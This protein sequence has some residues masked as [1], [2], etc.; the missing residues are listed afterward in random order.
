MR[1]NLEYQSYGHSLSEFYY[2]SFVEGTVI[3]V[4]KSYQG[5]FY[6][7]ERLQEIFHI[8]KLLKRRITLKQPHS[9]LWKYY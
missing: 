2:L 6:F 4:P 9:T 3:Q 8:Y 1:D 5:S 7:Q